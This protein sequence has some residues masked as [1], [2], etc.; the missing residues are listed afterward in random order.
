MVPYRSVVEPQAID[1][2]E[3]PDSNPGSIPTYKQQENQGNSANRRGS[4]HSQEQSEQQNCE[5][6]SASLYYR[7]VRYQVTLPVRIAR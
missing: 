6:L 2:S 5:K 4:L 1:P 3:M 7:L